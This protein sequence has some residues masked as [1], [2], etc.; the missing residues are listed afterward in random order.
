MLIEKLRWSDWK[1]I[2]DLY[3]KAESK[4]VKLRLETEADEEWRLWVSL[5]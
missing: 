1:V 4:A 3:L 2:E 5:D